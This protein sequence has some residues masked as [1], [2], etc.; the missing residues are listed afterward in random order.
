MNAKGEW[1]SFTHDRSPELVFRWQ[2]F[3]PTPY[4]SP[5]P[6]PGFVSTALAE[7]KIPANTPAGKYRIKHR[8]VAVPAGTPEAFEG[9]SEAFDGRPPGPRVV[10]GGFCDLSTFIQPRSRIAAAVCMRRRL[11]QFKQRRLA[12]GCKR[13]QHHQSVPGLSKHPLHW[14]QQLALPP[15]FIRKQQCVQWQL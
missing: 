3:E 14:H 4:L 12:C 15:R 9:V 6:L 8:G 11:E 13:G 10:T 7:W 1:E 5:V 2:P